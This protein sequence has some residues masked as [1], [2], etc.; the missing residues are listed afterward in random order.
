M[1][2]LWQENKFNTDGDGIAQW[3]GDRLIGLQQRGNHA[4]LIVQLDYIV[5]ELNSYES[6]A[7]TQLKRSST[8][9]SA[10]VAFQNG[11]ERCSQCMQSQ[12]IQF[13]IDFYN[14]LSSIET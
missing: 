3:L 6:S 14:K 7:N 10:T 9:E 12:R 13:A 1:G 5:Y 4:D 2:N 11:F 8:V